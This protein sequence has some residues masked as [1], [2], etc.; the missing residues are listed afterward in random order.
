MMLKLDMLLM[1][2]LEMAV[3]VGGVVPVEYSEVVNY[4]DMLSV[5]NLIPQFFFKR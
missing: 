3:V 5:V 1:L 2:A 4:G